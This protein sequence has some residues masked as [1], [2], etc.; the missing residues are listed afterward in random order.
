M[1]DNVV[2][3]FFKLLLLDFF[4]L[5]APGQFGSINSLLL[6]LCL[7]VVPILLAM[8]TLF[9]SVM[10]RLLFPLLALMALPVLPC[11]VSFRLPVSHCGGGKIRGL[12]SFGCCVFCAFESFARIEFNVVLFSGLSV[13]S[14]KF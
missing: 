12:D 10:R 13:A 8:P 5:I 4:G 3:F 1:L 9:Q 6:S 14:I 11:V 7:C 2:N